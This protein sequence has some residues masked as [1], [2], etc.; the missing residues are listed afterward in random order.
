LT[1]QEATE[2]AAS[3]AF[4]KQNETTLKATLKQNLF[5]GFL[6][7]ATIR[8][9]EL[10]QKTFEYSQQEAE[11][12]LLAETAQN[13]FTILSLT[14]DFL[15]YQQEISTHQKRREEILNLK[16]VGRAREIDLV[17]I[18]LSIANLEA[19]QANTNGLLL[20]ARETLSFLSGLPA[21]TALSNPSSVPQAI[22]PL[23][24]WLSGVA[25][26]PDVLLAEQELALANQGIHVAKAGYF[27]SAD[28]VG[29]YY[30]DRPGIASDINWDVMLVLSFNIFEGFVNRSFLREALSLQK[31]KEI[32][33]RNIKEQAERDIRANY[34]ILVADMADAYK[35]A[36]AKDLAEK[37]V[38][39]LTKEN[40]MG[41][42][43][44]MDVLESLATVY[45]MER[46]LSRAEFVAKNDFAKLQILTVSG[47]IDEKISLDSP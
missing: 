11:L 6:D 37:R 40:R 29:D 25:N 45:Q 18:D 31:E 20:A 44:N 28:L 10:Q 14:Q 13:F 21:Q 38:E 36:A 46:A 8:Q 26:R 34:Q 47:D 27:P 7:G 17:A 5:K 24:T 35:L 43:S 4:F 42:S 32:H 33:L 30:F 2:N 16:K 39:L 12:Q 19:A 3:Q 22:A 23:E 15:T 41:L 9:K 1:V